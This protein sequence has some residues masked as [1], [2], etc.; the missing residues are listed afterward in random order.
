MRK[1]LNGIW[2]D[3]YPSL[4]IISETPE[5]TNF[6]FAAGQA[7]RLLS[8]HDGFTRQKRGRPS[9][10]LEALK[11]AALILI[12]TAWESFVECTVERELKKRL[13]MA[14]SP[15]DV[16]STFNVVAQ[17]WLMQSGSNKPKPPDLARWAGDGWKAHIA[18]SLQSYLETFNTPNSANVRALFKRYVGLDVTQ[19][20]SWSRTSAD[21]ACSKLDKMILERGAVVHRA[22]TIHP[23]TP[24]EPG[25]KRATVV[26]ALNLTYNLVDK[27]EHA[28]GVEPS[29]RKPD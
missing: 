28:L 1:R 27:T 4:W 20:W 9:E 16:A 15:S 29:C 7:I 5:R 8:I 6:H 26:D 2:R 13:Q 10:D 17:Q 18:A 12:V 24:T 25:V 22:V 23:L 21:S 19:N 11:R 3:V 14:T